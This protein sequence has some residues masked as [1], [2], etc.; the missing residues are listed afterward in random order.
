MIARRRAGGLAAALFALVALF[1]VSP[2]H[3]EVS[4]DPTV[5]P[6]QL[7]N[8]VES[9]VHDEFYDKGGL[10]GFDAAEAEYRSKAARPAELP[11]AIDAWLGTLRASHTGR[12]TPDEIAYYELADI[13]SR[14]MGRRLR[15]AFPPDGEVTY[16]GIGIAPRTVGGK[17]FAADVYDGSPAARAGI[18]TGDEIVSVDG[19]PYAE[20]GSFE[21]QVG[22]SVKL[23]VRRSPGTAP[24]RIDVPVEAIRPNETFEKA[25]RASARVIE[26]DGHRIGYLRLWSF[27]SPAAEDVV[28]DIVA[29]E[30]LKSADGLIVDMRGRWGGAPAD[31][32]DIFLGK[33]PLIEMAGRDRQWEIA[34][35]RWRKPVVGIVDEGSRSGMEILAH[36]LKNAGVRLVGTRTAGAVLAARAFML[37]DRSLLLLAVAD[38]RV[39]GERLEGVGVTPDVEVPYDIRYAAGADPQLARAVEEIS[40]VLSD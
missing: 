38:V 40:R 20:I 3:A 34:N 13:F 4:L 16:P 23:E 26:R 11:A 25:I 28:M 17:I 33:A 18:V 8:Q 39:D 22:K 5:S 15:A 36:G 29:S 37:G 12:Y 21:G 1:A 2:S 27:A 6:T 30:P 32:A 31:A 35:V 14:G 10:S 19:K 7:L 24:M 9:V